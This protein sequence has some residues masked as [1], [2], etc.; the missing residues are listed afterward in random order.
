MGF[1]VCSLQHIHVPFLT[2]FN[3]VITYLFMHGSAVLVWI[4]FATAVPVSYLMFAIKAI[5]YPPAKVCSPKA[6]FNMLL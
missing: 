1:R 5:Q 2:V 6:A 4:G 3:V